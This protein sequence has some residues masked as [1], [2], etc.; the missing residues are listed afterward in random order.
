MAAA[1][2][3]VLC[4]L[5]AGASPRLGNAAV[6]MYAD[7]GL[8][9]AA[10]HH[11]LISTAPRD[12]VT[13]NTLISAYARHRRPADALACLAHMRSDGLAPDHVTLACLLK[14]CTAAAATAPD[15][16]ATAL[17]NGEEILEAG[18]AIAAAIP[19]PPGE[20]GGPRTGRDAAGE[21]RLLAASVHMY[22]TCGAMAP[23]EELLRRRRHLHA[24]PHHPDDTAAWNAL[25]AGYTRH[26]QPRDALACFFEGLLALRRSASA[27]T[28]V[29]VAAACG[30][31]GALARG[32]HVHAD[33]TRRGLLDSVDAVVL[34]GA[35][36]DM[37]A[38]CGA[39]ATARL[40]LRRLPART[41]VAWSALV[42]AYARHG[43]SHRALECAHEMRLLDGLAP[44]AVT[45][46]GLLRAASFSLPFLLPPDAAPSLSVPSTTAI[47]R[48]MMAMMLEH[49]IVPNIHHVACL[50]SAYGSVGHLER[51]MW[52]AAATPHHRLGDRGGDAQSVWLALLGACQKWGNAH[53]GRHAFC[54]AVQSKD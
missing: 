50:V 48:M 35:L 17:A 8:L 37:Y 24:R 6:A 7:R 32:H 14:A 10:R 12:T 33:A 45:F 46:L 15:V 13:W 18:R 20:S 34:G 5:V 2:R 9:A 30:R 40:V 16:T 47:I 42:S 53:L 36:V 26:G 31:A 1:E 28:Y 39:L 21:R 54:K 4:G 38:R 44:N 22:A 27:V 23:A 19:I 43:L 25:I 52:I 3:A 41:V 29:C 49:R 51:A 11:A